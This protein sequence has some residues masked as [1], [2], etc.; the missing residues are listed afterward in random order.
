[1]YKYLVGTALIDCEFV[2]MF[3]VVDWQFVWSLITV[4]AQTTHTVAQSHLS[5]VVLHLTCSALDSTPVQCCAV[6][7]WSLTFM[8]LIQSRFPLESRSNYSATSNNMKL[9]HWPLMVGC[10]IWYS[11]EGTG[12]GHRPLRPLLAVLNVTAHPSTV[13]VQSPYCCIMV[14]CSDV[15]IEG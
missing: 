4:S 12:L 1:M 5:S 11:K 13:S 3:G 2:V 10:Y 6:A 8:H 15:P 9:V 7:G 14:H